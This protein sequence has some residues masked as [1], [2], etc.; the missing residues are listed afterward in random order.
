MS[1]TPSPPGPAEA[2]ARPGREALVAGLALLA[3]LCLLWRDSIFGGKV[4]SQADAL[5]QFQPWSGVAPKGFQPSNE[6][7]LDQA[8]G[9]LP[10]LEFQA[11]E[12]RRGS[13][14]LWNPYCYSGEPFASLYQ[15]SLFSPLN[16]IYY[17]F[18]SWHTHV[19][20]ACVKLWLAGFLTYLFLRR[21]GT[22]AGAAALGGLAFML[23]G[24]MVAWLG[25]HHTSCALFLPGVLW[26]VERMAARP[27][28]RE[29]ALFGAL[30]GLQFLAGHIQ[31]SLLLGLA[32]LGYA[33][34]RLAL[35]FASARLS[36]RGV[37]WLL[38]GGLLGLVVSAPQM[39]PFL[40]F[41]P[42]TQAGKVFGAQQVV[43]SEGVRAAAIMLLDP[44][45]Y[46]APHT[47]DYRGPHG[48][49]LNFSE[50]IGGYVGR[51]VLLL[52]S[53]QIAWLG[54]TRNRRAVTA[55]FLGLA[56]LG[57]L[58][59]YQ[60]EPIYGW[61]QATPILAQ[62]K[63]MRLSLFLAFG[64]AVLAAL[65]LDALLRRCSRPRL[66][67]ALAV[68]A[69]GL[70]AAEQT[71][72]ARGYNPEVDP[73]S[74]VPR[75][76][77]TDFL[78]QQSGPY[79]VLGVH[80][81]YL[82]PNAN[83]FYRVPMISGYNS[84]EDSR[85]AE[86]LLRT[87]NTAP[88]FPFVSEIAAFD[89]IEALPL[90]SLLGA[91]FVLSPGP[92]PPPLRK[93]LNGEVEVYENP[94]ALPRAFLARG[95]H[96]VTDAKARVERMTAPDFDPWQALVEQE[97]EANATDWRTA[98]A[99]SAGPIPQ[100]ERVDILDHQADA[101]DLRVAAP[102]RALLVLAETW[103]PGWVAEVQP[104]AAATA[105]ARAAPIAR[106]DHALRGIWVE[107][108]DWRIR[109]SYRP[110]PVRLGIVFALLAALALGWLAIH[111]FRAERRA[112]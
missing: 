82:R 25:F 56:V 31:T 43:A 30:V 81:T 66:A 80:N 59:G 50:L 9:F 4:L 63:L 86:L 18:P 85:Y 3:V 16:W 55:C 8:T 62:T 67:L 68:G 110:R 54:W 10:W 91:R 79:R 70:V 106:V 1:L 36:R 100:T 83:M 28:A 69:F 12:L 41:L 44:F 51:A 33:A 26:A 58:G 13:L 88:R 24:F 84:M 34:L 7:L 21:L 38:A 105:T 23:C 15:T 107:P 22:R 52:A 99:A 77:V 20:T 49:N 32:T 17:A 5:N 40:E 71:W 109:L 65:G 42:R 75:T 73:A 101:I 14:P 6:L 102:R 2:T 48:P 39:L 53:L 89:R 76:A 112:A 87:T 93:V 104:A 108:G 95:V 46:G 11:A 92:L 94:L 19:W 57:L 29:G 27:R 98:F 74:L 61:L 78:R 97:P 47:H 96:V 60:I 37:L 64:L 72:F 103:D 111:P 45:H 90:F 35:P